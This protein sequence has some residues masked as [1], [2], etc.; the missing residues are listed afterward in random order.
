VILEHE[1]LKEAA[2]LMAVR[3]PDAL[4]LV[5]DAARV[6]TG[7]RSWSLGQTKYCVAY[8]AKVSWLVWASRSSALARIAARAYSLVVSFA[9]RFRRPSEVSIVKQ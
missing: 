3:A 5:E 1:A 7:R 4:A 9:E 6:K 2:A 8:S